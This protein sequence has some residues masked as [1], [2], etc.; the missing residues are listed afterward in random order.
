MI[1]IL[2]EI[3]LSKFFNREM[4]HKWTEFL[5]NKLNIYLNTGSKYMF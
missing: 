2:K 5:Q 3:N 4:Q 1:F